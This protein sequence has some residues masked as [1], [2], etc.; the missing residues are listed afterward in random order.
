MTNNEK[1]TLFTGIVIVLIAYM[2]CI[3]LEISSISKLREVESDC[4]VAAGIIKFNRRY[5]DIQIIHPLPP[6]DIGKA[7][8]IH[9]SDIDIPALHKALMNY[10][11]D[12]E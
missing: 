5:S 2:V 10:K 7:A 9:P 8:K 6:I 1:A 12:R 4:R 3:L 11:P